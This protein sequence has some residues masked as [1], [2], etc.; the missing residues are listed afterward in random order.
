MNEPEKRKKVH[1][2]TTTREKMFIVYITQ[3]VITLTRFVTL[4]YDAAEAE[5]SYE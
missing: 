1:F 4:T 3:S 5:A 2:L